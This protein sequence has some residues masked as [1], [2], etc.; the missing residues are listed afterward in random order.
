[1]LKS[2]RGKL[3]VITLLLSL[4]P[5]LVTNAYQL[6]NYNRDQDNEIALHLQDI[7]DTKAEAINLWLQEKIALIDAAF[8]N[9]PEIQNTN[10][11][12]AVSILSSIKNQYSDIDNSILADNLGNAITEQGQSFSI[13]DREYFE[14]AKKANSTI[15]SDIVTSKGTGNK[16]IA[17]VKPIRHNTGEFKGLFILSI[18]AEKIINIINGIKVGQ[19]GYGYLLNKDSTVFLVH[20]TAPN[21]GKRVEEVNPEVSKLFNETLFKNHSGILEYTASDKTQRL[22]HYHL[23][24]TANWQLVVTGKTSEILQGVT[25]N[26]RVVFIM[27][28]FTVIIVALLGLFLGIEFTR[29]IKIVNELLVKTEQLDLIDDSIL[30]K[31]YKRKDETGIMAKALSSTRKTIRELIGKFQQVSLTLE[32]NTRRLYSTLREITGSIEN[33]AKAVDDMAQSST[34]LAQNTQTGSEKLTMLSKEIEGINNASSQVK[35]FIDDSIKAKDNGMAIVNK[36][37][38]AV[39]DNEAVAR[40]VGEKVFLLDE[41]SQKIS[42]ITETIK[43]I[44][45]KVN[46]LSLNAAIESARVGEAGRGFA[47]V[48]KEI[49]KLASDTASST[50][51]IENIINEFKKIIEDTKKEIVVTLE[52]IANTSTMSRVTGEAFDSIDRSVAS[53]IEKIDYLIKGISNISKDKEEAVKTIEDISAFSEQSA[54]TTEEISAAVQEQ[55]AN[56]QQISCSAETLYKITTELNKLVEEFKL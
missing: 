8:K 1:M 9:H 45:S 52:V 33:T 4:I 30:E 32:D 2:I 14:R 12:D 11:N 42:L 24:E 41:K 34:E 39:F 5:L 17:F 6:Y 29:P 54:S 21:I 16:V 43:N 50:I 38:K 26:I 19:T 56:L 46:L 23:I 18:N 13:S 15:V 35:V 40:R 28:I 55:S 20:P 53:I 51:E 3:L 31:L 37:K 47:V 7:S 27:T 10:I 48:A 49:K 22:A 36:L 44:T 25:K